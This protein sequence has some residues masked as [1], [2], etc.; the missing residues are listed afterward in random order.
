M[1]TKVEDSDILVKSEVSHAELNVTAHRQKLPNVVMMKHNLL[2][3]LAA[4][5][6]EKNFHKYHASFGAICQ[7]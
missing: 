5:M 7:I 2:A 1:K 4:K 3:I 6:T